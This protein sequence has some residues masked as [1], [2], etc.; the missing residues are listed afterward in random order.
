MHFTKA[1]MEESGNGDETRVFV[2]VLFERFGI[3]F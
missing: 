3:V 2:T 1:L